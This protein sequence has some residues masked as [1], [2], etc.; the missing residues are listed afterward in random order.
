VPIEAQLEILGSMGKGNYLNL[1]K[2]GTNP[3]GIEIHRE[4]LTEV[5]HH[6]LSNT[7]PIMW[8]RPKFGYQKYQRWVTYWRND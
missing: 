6:P 5:V 3:R 8:K 4:A 1:P 2:P 7:I